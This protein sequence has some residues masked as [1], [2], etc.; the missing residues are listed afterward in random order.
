MAAARASDR[1]DFYS[2]FASS[3]SLSEEEL[4]LLDKKGVGKEKLGK[5][6]AET[7][8][9][10]QEWLV[11]QATIP[12]GKKLLLSAL[13]R[14]G[15]LSDA[16]RTTLDG[17]GLTDT[18]EKAQ[19]ISVIGLNEAINALEAHDEFKIAFDTAIRA[20]GVPGGI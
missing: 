3:I 6:Q 19:A 5:L 12:A 10:L 11:Y 8:D 7:V 13:S 20:E 16:D 2:I 1:T 18:F 4:E 9:A 14:H 17:A 15:E